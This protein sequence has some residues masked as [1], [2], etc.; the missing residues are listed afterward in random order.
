M[1]IVDTFTPNL[2]SNMKKVGFPV[3]WLWAIMAVQLSAVLFEGIGIGMILPIL[4]RL[5]DTGGAAAAQEPSAITSFIENA[6]GVIGVP[7]TL[8][9]LLVAC[10]ATILVRQ[11]FFFLREML[12]GYVEYEMSRRIRDQAF[13]GFVHASLAYHD[14]IRSGEFVNETT[15]ELKNSLANIKSGIRFFSYSLMLVGYLAIAAALSYEMTAAAAA[16][17]CV[18]GVLLAHLTR[19]MREISQKVTQANQSLLSFL[20]ERLKNVRL[21]RLSGMESAEMNVLGGRTLYQRNQELIRRRMIALLG[22]AIEPVVLFVALVL[23]YVS[24]EILA[25]PLEQILLFFFIL[26]RMVPILKDM[27]LSRQNY[28]STSAS[29]EVLVDRLEQLKTNRSTHAG[30]RAFTGLRDR[31]AF[32]DLSFSYAGHG[33]EEAPPVLRN[34]NATIAAGSLTALVGPSGAGK[35]TLVDFIPLLRSPTGGRLMI[36]GAS[37]EDFSSQS[38][39]DHIAY[40]PQQPQIFNVTVADHIGYGARGAT[41]AQIKDAAKLA[42]AHDFIQALPDGYDTLLGENGARLS[43][44]QRQRLDLARA[45][46]QQTSILIL[47]EPTSALDAESERQFRS[48]LSQIRATGRLTVIIIAHRLSTV[49]DADS[50][51]VLRDGSVDAQGTHQD[52]LATCPWYR[53]AA[54]D[55]MLVSVPA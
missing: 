30:T 55:Q 22:I 45:L 39:R 18:T 13:E 54:Q 37:A 20:V 48:A 10:F 38:L 47:D 9:T 21:L 43:G 24:T 52:L 23:L 17:F 42:N 11:L 32:K 19:R 46:A 7:V 29:I 35:S 3:K 49:A 33:T 5:S 6:F 15:V 27:I 14:T 40:V 4:E 2:S 12:A 25:V 44:G 28:I 1:F 41:A 51:I 36:D 34:V 26:I 16:V 50:I 53:R 8:L 31:I